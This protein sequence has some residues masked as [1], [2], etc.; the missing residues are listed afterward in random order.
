MILS[1]IISDYRK[2]HDGFG[3]DPTEKICHFVDVIAVVFTGAGES[4]AAVN[5]C[6]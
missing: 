1:H 2:K 5:T 3:D 4:E 6:M